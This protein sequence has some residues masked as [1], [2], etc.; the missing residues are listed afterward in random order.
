MPNHVINCLKIEGEEKRVREL[1][2]YI[3]DNDDEK[4][5][6]DF[7][8][9]LPMPK[10]VSWYDWSI[11]NWGTK[12]NS[13]DNE[14][15]SDNEIRF[16]TAWDGIVELIKRLSQ[17]YADL[18]FIYNYA[19]EDLSYN[20]GKLEIKNGEIVNELDCVENGS[21]AAFEISI[22]LWDI[23]DD[24]VLIGDEYIH[25]DELEY[26]KEQQQQYL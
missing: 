16:Q 12:W 3:K 2:D 5:L 20:F 4:R 25:R 26:E 6:I 7:N 15:I 13:Y 14:K 22:D 9:I 1:F 17:N 23:R 8:K 21:K 19:D 11:A 10:G 18:N 24:Y